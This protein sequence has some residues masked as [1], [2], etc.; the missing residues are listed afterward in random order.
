[1]RFL[2]RS[3]NRLQYEAVSVEQFAFENYSCALSRHFPHKT[4][5]FYPAC[6]FSAPPHPFKNIEGTV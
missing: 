1:M 5:G 3:R 4:P 2:L 6:F